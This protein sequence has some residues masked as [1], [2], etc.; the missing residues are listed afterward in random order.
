MREEK[1]LKESTI[2]TLKKKVVK[3]KPIDI[4][5]HLDLICEAESDMN[6]IKRD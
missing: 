5:D 1:Y 2:S 3:L 6:D 4:H